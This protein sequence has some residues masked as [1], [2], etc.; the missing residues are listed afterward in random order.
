MSKLPNVIWQKKRFVAGDVLNHSNV[1][2]RMRTEK[3]INVVFSINSMYRK[4]GLKGKFFFKKK[5]SCKIASGQLWKSSEI[6]GGLFCYFLLNWQKWQINPSGWMSAVKRMQK[7]KNNKANRINGQC[8][9]FKTFN[10]NLSFLSEYLDCIGG[11]RDTV[12]DPPPE[13]PPDLVR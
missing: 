2:I 9:R 5:G 11:R 7:S 12:T 3:R 13:L 6:F 8:V 10:F 1:R 4:Q